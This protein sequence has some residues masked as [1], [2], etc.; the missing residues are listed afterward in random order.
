MSGKTRKINGVDCGPN[1][2][3]HV[4]NP[5]DPNTWLFCVRVLG[6]NDKTINA[7]K[8]TLHNFERQKQAIPLGQRAAIWNRL[9]GAALCLGLVVQKDPVVTVT[10]DEL[11]F[12]LAERNA[13][14]LVSRISMEWGTQ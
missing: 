7:V 8:T 9:V 12:I 1:C 13:T 11:D 6:D 3:A 14:E 10:D 4:G 5:E 2:F